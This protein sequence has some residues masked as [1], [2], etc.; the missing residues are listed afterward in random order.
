MDKRN[1]KRSVFQDDDRVKPS[2][3]E[4]V[5][6]MLRKILR[7]RR[8]FFPGTAVRLPTYYVA[9]HGHSAEAMTNPCSQALRTGISS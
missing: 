4:E 5:Q 1:E 9:R 8:T 2:Y 7:F 6:G 3:I